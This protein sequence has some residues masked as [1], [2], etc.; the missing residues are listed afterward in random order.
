MNILI[1]PLDWGLGHATRDIPIINKLIA[2]GHTVII[3]AD[4]APLELLKIEFP[5]LTFICFKSFQIKYAQG[6]SQ[7]FSLIFSIPN[8][9]YHILCEHVELKKIIRQFNIDTVISDNRYGLW[10]KKVKCTF[11]THQ[12]FIKLPKHWRFLEGFVFMI[13]KWFIS[14]FDECWIPDFGTF[15][16]LSGDL[17]HGKI[18]P[19]NAKYI[20]ILSRFEISDKLIVKNL[21]PDFNILVV[22][23]GPEPQRTIFERILVEQLK[24]TAFKTLIVLGKPK[25]LS[26]KRIEIK[27]EANLVFVNHLPTALLQNAILK[28]EVVICRSGYTSVMDLVKLDAKAILVPTPGQTEQEYLAAYLMQQ[29]YFFSMTQTEFDLNVAIKKYLEFKPDKVF[30]TLSGL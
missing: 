7:A 2:D 11:I 14:K 19:V 12:I 9:L 18:L 24:A 10:N 8:I 23:S 15:P 22:L 30:K 17:S 5:Q 25:S 20:G 29:N 6:K 1:C 26:K 28:A 4:N 3:A 21:L 13:N 16:N 27:N